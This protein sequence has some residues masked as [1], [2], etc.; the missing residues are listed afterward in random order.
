MSKYILYG[1][2]GCHLCDLASDV[3]SKCD[4]RATKIDIA[5]K[6]ELME[7]YAVR[8]PVLKNTATQKELTWPFDEQLLLSWLQEV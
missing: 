6:P 5:H 2:L 7:F 3:L 1:T 4:V 8:I